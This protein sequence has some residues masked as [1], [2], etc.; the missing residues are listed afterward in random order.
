[1]LLSF[2]YMNIFKR[3]MLI[4]AVACVVTAVI[5]MYCFNL[6]LFFA[7][8]VIIILLGFAV[9]KGKSKYI[10]VGLAFCIFALSLFLEHQ[11]IEAI[12]EFD[13]EIASGNFLV[14]SQPKEYNKFNS[15]TFKAIDC[16]GLPKGSKYLVFDYSK[17]QLQQG[18][19]L[20]AEIKINTIKQDDKY[21]LY[22]YANSVYATASAKVVKKLYKVNYFYKFAYNIRN[23]VKST[24]TSVADGDTAGLLI[25][26]TIGDKS[27]LTDN[28]TDSV[29]TTGVSHVIVISGMHLSIIMSVIFLL[30][31]KLFYNKYIRSLLSIFTVLIISAVCGFTMSITRAGVMFIIASLAPIFN[32][33]NDL[34]NSLFTAITAV[35]IVTPFAIF[36]I[37]FQL[38]ILATLAIVWVLPFYMQIFTERF[39]V[40]SKFIKTVL[41]IIFGSL[42]ATVFTMPVSIK[43]FGYVSVVSPITNLLITYPV[44]AVITF[45]VIALVLSVI[46]GFKLFSSVIFFI[47]KIC[48]SYIVFIVNKISYLPITVATLSENAFI[49]SV[50]LIALIIAFMYIY[51]FKL[52]KEKK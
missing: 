30:L 16:D 34:L 1:M 19:I 49:F 13:K 6:A 8:A 10:A 31:D 39:N 24:I 28:F 2:N 12:N 36:N 45:N 17:T 7:I 20:Y 27:M 50:L 25:A 22:D 4:S 51:N 9:F 32:R 21:R 5:S 26:L 18:D 15:I 44:T 52:K 38:S 35:L 33:E 37:S 46:P 29:R 23:Y 43:T 47:T 3:P 48:A 40:N 11:K 41:N 14:V 42:F